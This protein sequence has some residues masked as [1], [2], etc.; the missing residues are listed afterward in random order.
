[1]NKRWR[2]ISWVALITYLIGM[3]TVLFFAYKGKNVQAVHVHISDTAQG[4]VTRQDIRQL[5]ATGFQVDSQKV[6]QVDVSEVEDSIRALPAVATAEAYITGEGV[7]T[8]EITPETPILRVIA[9]GGENFYLARSGALIPYT[10]RYVPLVTVANGN[11]GVP[12]PLPLHTGSV[13]CPAVLDDLYAIGKEIR[14]HNIWRAQIEQIYAKA[15]GEY[16]LIPRIGAHVILLGKAHDVEWKF[17]KLMALYKQGFTQTD[18]NKYE[19]INLKYKN[20]LV[21]TIR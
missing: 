4:F 8:V 12:G 9:T 18:W 20:Q 5:L 19:Y 16:E 11:I 13:D 14:S 17:R 10:P 7:L 21:C 1:M 2:I 15:N 3:G 6:S